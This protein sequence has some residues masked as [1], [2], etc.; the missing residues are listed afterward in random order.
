MMTTPVDEGMPTLDRTSPHDL[1]EIPPVFSDDL[2]EFSSDLPETQ[3]YHVFQRLKLLSES[4]DLRDPY[5]AEIITA[6]EFIAASDY[7]DLE[8]E[9]AHALRTSRTSYAKVIKDG[10]FARLR[11]YLDNYDTVDIEG[12]DTD[13]HS[14]D[15]AE[16]IIVGELHCPHV[17]GVTATFEN[18]IEQ[19]EKLGIEVT[20]AGL[21]GGGWTRERLHASTAS[22]TIAAPHCKLICAHLRGHY[23]IWEHL[24]TKER[25]VLTNVTGIHELFLES[26]TGTSAYRARHLCEDPA[27]FSRC[28]KELNSGVSTAKNLM[29]NLPLARTPGAKDPRLNKDKWTTSREYTG[30]WGSD[31]SVR[32]ASLSASVS[33][34]SRFVR[35]I[36][37]TL[38]LPYGFHYISRYRSA[39]ELPQ[40][41]AAQRL[42]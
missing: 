10:L 41:W 38:E 42:P 25:I 27:S 26:L 3:P 20:A 36:T 11:A 14:L 21:G 22:L 8:R 6:Q 2:P 9:V 17:N 31:V 13:K 7:Y 30:S 16:P 29:E 32:G 35:T 40:Q 5:W 39:R 23:V 15:T 34:T 19:S 28:F 24:Q 1:V 18:E 33:Y 4:F 37:I 12:S